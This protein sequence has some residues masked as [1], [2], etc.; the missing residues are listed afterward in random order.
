M[1][2][3]TVKN[4]RVRVSKELRAQVERT[5]GRVCHLCGNQISAGQF[6]A[7][8]VKSVRAGGSTVLANCRPAHKTCNEFRS[9]RPLTDILRAECRVR[10]ERIHGL[11]QRL[12]KSSSHSHTG[13]GANA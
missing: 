7:D 9:S 4:W 5:Y 12:V 13:E 2:G 11:N 8:H 3:R 10:Y 6:T 1:T